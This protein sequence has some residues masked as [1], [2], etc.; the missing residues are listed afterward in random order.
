MRFINDG[1]YRTII[2]LIMLFVTMFA[3]NADR[4]SA[5]EINAVRSQL[6]VMHQMHIQLLAN[7]SKLQYD[8]LIATADY[9][10]KSIIEYERKHANDEQSIVMLKQFEELFSKH[11][12][13]L[14][15]KQSASLRYYQS[16]YGIKVDDAFTI[17]VE[18]TDK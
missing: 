17:D 13:L 3:I 1:S 5:A 18:Q 16:L 9:F 4:K 15:E 14:R 12:E 10:N 6:D 8:A 11:I 2:T 7:E